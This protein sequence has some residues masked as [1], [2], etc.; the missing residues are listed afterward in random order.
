MISSSFKG[1]FGKEK[2]DKLRLY[3]PDFRREQINPENDSPGPA[4]YNP[5]GSLDKLRSTIGTSFPKVRLDLWFGYFLDS[6]I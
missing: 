5:L 3:H 2:R 1:A 4:I 6:L